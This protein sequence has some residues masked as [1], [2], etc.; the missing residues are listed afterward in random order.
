MYIFINNVP[1]CLN[2]DNNATWF[3]EEF[4][5]LSI[6]YSYHLD[7]KPITNNCVI[8]F[9]DLHSIQTIGGDKLRKFFDDL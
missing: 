2:N 5:P 8:N 9:F 6:L 1:I 3:G 7:V 4:N